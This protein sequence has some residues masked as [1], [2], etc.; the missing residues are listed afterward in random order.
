[1]G[2]RWRAGLV[3]VVVVLGVLGLASSAAAQCP[4]AN[5]SAFG[6]CGPTFTLPQWGDAG[7]WTGQDQYSTIQF[8]RVLGNSREQLI[9]RSAHGI[10]IWDFDTTLGQWRPAV[11]A[12]NKPMIL[13]SF[14]DPPRLTQTHPTFGGTDWTAPGHFLTIQ[15][16]DVLGNG[17]D[18]IIARADSGITVWSYT[19]G[20]NAAAGTWSQVYSGEPFSDADGFAGPF[21]GP[22][23]TIHTADLTGDGKAD[24]FGDTPS[25]VV[26]AYE[27]N[28]SGF[29]QLP[30]IPDSIPPLSEMAQAQTLRA[31]PTIDGRQELWWA[32]V[33]G[34]LGLR[35]NN[36]R[37][38]WT[39]VN[40]PEAPLSPG[41]CALDETSPT[42][43]GSP[44]Y[45]PTCRVVNVTG[46][47]NEVQVVGRGVDGLDLWKLT[48]QGTWQQLATLTA[49]SDA[50]GWN[51][52][53]YYGSIQYANL[54][55]STTGQQEM[56]ARGP[57]GVVIYKY[58]ETANAWSQLPSSN[59]LG[60]TDDPWGG[61]PSYYSTLRL[62]DAS[63]DGIQDTLIARGPYGIRT[64][65]YGRPAQTGWSIYAPAGYPA[66]PGN[67]P[68]AYTALNALPAIKAFLASSS[69][70][71]IRA[72]LAQETAPSAGDL[73]S[74]QSV[75]ALAAGCSGE[76]ASLPYPQYA[77]CTPPT[78]ITA[79][80]WTNVVNELLHETWNAQQ[81][82]A[83]YAELNTISQELFIAE[84]AEL[85]AIA[86]KLNLT[87][88]TS[89]PTTWDMKGFWSGM[90]GI[91]ASAAFEFPPLSA[92]LWATAEFVSMLPSASPDL[93]NDFAGTYNQLQ[94]VFAS[95]ISETQKAEVSQ[96]Q[97]VRSDLNL[98]TLVAQLREQGTWAMDDTGIQSASNQ[99]FATSVYKTLMPAMYTRY[100][101]TNCD[102]NGDGED[103]DPACTGPSGAGAAGN[104]T[105]FAEIGVPPTPVGDETDGTPCTN[106][107]LG[108]ICQYQDQLVD[109]SIGNAIWGRVPANCDYQPGNPNTVWTFG[110]PLGVNPATSVNA[111]LFVNGSSKEYWAFP[112]Y[113]GTPYVDGSSHVGGTAA[114]A[115]TGVGSS[116]GRAATVSLRGAFATAR[117]VDV[118]RASV[119][120][121]RVLFDPHGAG[122]LLRHVAAP[123]PGRTAA[124]SS[125][126]PRRVAPT[127][128]RRT[129]AGTF[130]GPLSA[131]PGQPSPRI[132]LKLTPGRGRS[133][134][135]GLRIGNVAIPVPPAA[136]VLGTLGVA[137]SAAPFPLTLKL[138]L[139]QP[140]RKP[141]AISV[142]PLFTC[143]RDRTGAI[144][145][146]TVVKPKRPKLGPGLSVIIR[147]PGR[148]KMGEA[149]RL[150]MTVRNRAQRP[151]Y[152]VFIRA[153]L[154]VGLRVVS[155]SPRA[156]VRRG[157]ILWRMTKLRTRKSHTIHLRVVPTRSAR[158]C[159]TVTA[160]AVLRKQSARRACISV[161]SARTP[162]SGLG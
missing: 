153:F 117:R 125:R 141:H 121:N 129:G 6:P 5:P 89:T 155:H 25:G 30:R 138:T 10:E 152:D 16:A 134:A 14:A 108:N 21:A 47:T 83:F 143:Q 150:T 148:L 4:A 29:T 64:W 93:T 109:S 91:A 57:N 113:I 36:A 90:L 120:L 45:Y 115:G 162:P 66:F 78:G 8:G 20:T 160:T 102:A 39:R 34:M 79:T 96:S 133:L 131:L 60:L 44:H 158:R 130:S 22:S 98:L 95:G 19:P 114:A 12:Q 122:E 42:P 53:K 159:T 24:L 84:G 88:A 56:I 50:H 126:L 11:D 99:A 87:Q 110:C 31:S 23:Q 37:D 59:A 70:G 81:V 139:R 9:G 80:D 49:V 97:Q 52:Q 7:G 106:G 46:D 65:F 76:Q 73:S 105:N 33:F 85:P 161:I 86:G 107:Q 124:A 62:G 72:Y 151:A 77:T 3:S 71:T 94:N 118:S 154:P 40:P 15:V 27:W 82:V 100:V 137:S 32:A 101:V 123:T 28:G 18:Q 147:R 157:M 26:Q 136:C 144:R 111:S 35:L 58:D 1:M 48:S 145:A 149:G 135:F 41:P 43:W 63:G 54:D 119:V 146:L 69:V 75:I 38:G 67:E 128:L 68:A 17:R 156:I 51:Q 116:L 127:A 140:N 112:T 103:T 55:G 104:K 74:L 61:D 2:W 132:R 92:A 13:T 142:S